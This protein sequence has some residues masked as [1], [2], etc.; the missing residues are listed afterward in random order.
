MTRTLKRLGKD[1]LPHIP[2]DVIITSMV[3]KIKDFDHNE[4]IETAKG[5][6][7]AEQA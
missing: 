3:P 6:A 2:H 1:M 5:S 7:A 4:N